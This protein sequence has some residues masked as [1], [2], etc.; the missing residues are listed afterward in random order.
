MTSRIKYIFLDTNVFYHCKEYREIEWKS[1]FTEDLDKLII[2][3]PNMVLKELD[4]GKNLNKDYSIIA[5]KVISSFRVYEN[6]EFKEDIKLELSIFPPKWDKLDSE[7]KV[8]LDK[9]DKDHNIIAEILIFCKE[10]N[11]DDVIFITGDFLPFRIGT[12]LGIKVINWRDEKYNKLFQNLKIKKKKEFQPEIG[13]IMEYQ[14]QS[15]NLIEVSLEIDPPKYLKLENEKKTQSDLGHPL[16]DFKSDRVFQ[17]EID[18]YNQKIDDFSHYRRIELYAFNKGFN[19]YTNID[20]LI[21]TKL[22][23]DFIIKYERDVEMP[24]KPS[25]VINVASPIYTPSIAL[26]REPNVRY[27][28]VEKNETAKNTEWF[29]GFNIK[30]IKHNDSVSLYPIMLWIPENPKTKKIIFKSTFTQDEPGRIKPYYLSI[31]LKK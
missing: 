10:H 16:L 27:I 20:I 18:N 11:N 6:V 13:V 29:F 9:D 14:N 24:N 28:P 25:R 3:V 17:K 15:S 19:P 31:N 23:K 1:I 30:K 21:Y 7:S 26:R 5:R 12:K 8:L 4:Y 2:K 22:E